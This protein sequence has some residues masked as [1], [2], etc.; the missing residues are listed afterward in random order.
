MA[1]RVKK[2][3]NNFDDK[4]MRVL[5]HESDL[6]KS[7]L[8]FF[9]IQ[10]FERILEPF[11]CKLFLIMLPDSS[12]NIGEAALSNKVVLVRFEGVSVIALLGNAK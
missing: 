2:I 12:E 3:V 6:L 10:D 1:I 5:F 11:D 9:F 7:C 8:L 4:W